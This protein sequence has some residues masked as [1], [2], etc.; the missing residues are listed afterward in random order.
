M[1]SLIE[2]IK[3][4]A[5]VT[6]TS[7]NFEPLVREIMN[8]CCVRRC[9]TVSGESGCSYN[10]DLLIEGEGGKMAVN[11]NFGDPKIGDI[12]R[13][14]TAV[15]DIRANGWLY[16][17][18]PVTESKFSSFSPNIIEAKSLEDALEKLKK[19]LKCKGQGSKL[20]QNEQNPDGS[21]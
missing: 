10:L 1:D 9:A 17:S 21:F 3:N 4:F 12:I 20:Q 11:F 6:D 18:F 2:E 5:G 14:L 7:F 13:F 19:A 15:Y 8:I 16:I